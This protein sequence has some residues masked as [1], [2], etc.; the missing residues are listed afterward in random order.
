MFYD[1]EKVFSVF[2]LPKCHKHDSDPEIIWRNLI[3]TI[4]RFAMLDWIC[5]PIAVIFFKSNQ[6]ILQG[7]SKLDNI[8]KISIFQRNKIKSRKDSQNLSISHHTTTEG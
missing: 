1:T 3:E 5:L 4:H 8:V 7:V 2:D 6:D